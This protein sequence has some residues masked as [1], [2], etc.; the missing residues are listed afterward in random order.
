MKLEKAIVVVM[1]I[2]ACWGAAAE[3]LKAQMAREARSALVLCV[4]GDWCVSGMS[5]EKVY[6]SSAFRA[7]VGGKWLF[8]VNDVREGAA[9]VSVSNENARVKSLA[10]DTRRFPAL[11]VYNAAGEPVVRFENLPQDITASQM[12][13]M[14]KE[15]DRLREAAE[16]DFA[17]GAIGPGF[18]R[19]AYFQLPANER[20]FLFYRDRKKG[21]LARAYP[22]QWEKLMA[23]TSDEAKSWVSHFT[24]GDGIDDVTKANGLHEKP[25]EGKA[26]IAELR[27]RPQMH[28]SLEQRQSI[29]MAEF[30]LIRR[31]PEQKEKARALLKKVYAAGG[32]TFWGW[33]A[34]G[35][36]TD[37]AFGETVAPASTDRAACVKFGKGI[38]DRAFKPMTAAET[39]PST[40]AVEKLFTSFRGKVDPILA[41]SSGKLSEVQTTV[42]TR[43]WAL[44]EIG[45]NALV[46]V[47]GRTGG[48]AFTN[49]FL[50]DREWLEDFFASGPVAD[51]PAAFTNLFALVWNDERNEIR[52]GGLA[53]RIATAMAV[54]STG[55]HPTEQLVR[56]FA[57]YRFLA[58]AGRLHKTAYTQSVREWRFALGRILEASDLLYLNDYLNFPLENYGGACW[59]VPY[60]AHNC[61][62]ESVQRPTYYRPWRNSPVPNQSLRPQVGGV[63]GALS[64][65][66]A[67]SA[68]AHGLLATTGGQPGHCALNRRRGNGAWDINN[69]VGRFTT[70]HNTFWGHPF[71]YLDVIERGYADRPRQLQ[72]DRLLWLA[73]FAE[74][75]GA[76]PGKVE[77]WY[78]FAAAAAPKHFGVWRAYA[79][80][81]SR[82][83]SADEKRTATFFK[84]LVK[85]L[86]EGRQATWDLVNET[87]ERQT[88][89]AVVKGK[90]R[91][92]ARVERAVATLER[93]YPHLPQPTNTPTREEMNYRGLLDRQL[94]FVGDDTA[95]E[96]RLF[97]SVLMAQVGRPVF[98][99]VL[100]W[101]AARYLKDDAGAKNFVRLV[102]SVGTKSKVPVKIDCREMMLNAEK[103][104]NLAVFRSV[105]DLYDRLNPQPE[106]KR[107]PE[108]DFGG[109]LVSARGMLTASST[110]RWDHPE[111]HGRTTDVSPGSSAFH[112]NKETA[113][114]AIVVTA[115]K[116]WLG[117]KNRF[118]LIRIRVESRGNH[119]GFT[120]ESRGVVAG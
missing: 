38:V 86:P 100:G 119:W 92:E 65:F 34:Q 27:A 60:R 118:P 22:V 43:A 97:K 112:T 96:Q 55:K 71:T 17:K 13:Q 29:D 9:S 94:K 105:A 108:N 82:D 58:D 69:Y 63:C 5:V 66:G 103:T 44:H 18:Q 23:D 57:G 61:F 79:D 47:L 1:G 98:A 120:G 7:Q 90:V 101:G 19:L 95:R 36:L 31:D 46:F 91:D 26:F 59:C 11:F 32:D 68:N 75:G 80:W 51:A 4:G 70:A 25:E 2:C 10:P 40:Q 21:W 52:A 73:R 3:D 114:W 6:R 76:A 85:G 33:A 104:G 113:P 28:W 115:R 50:K 106:G 83:K 116:L 64:T 30:A 99:E 107:Y 41:R 89:G 84:A 8:G 74:E 53:R 24:M 15:G 110:C 72:A 87:L 88:K 49:A 48:R 67:L 14:V 37:D 56:T 109:R 54:Q 16:A 35:Y 77:R 45:T 111:L 93:L 12:A 78:Q 81:L 20:P 117:L 42:L 39:V 62:G 102:E